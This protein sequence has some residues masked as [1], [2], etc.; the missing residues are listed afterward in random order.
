MNII[1]TG[2]GKGIGFELCKIFLKHSGTH[3]LAISRDITQLEI[4][5]K[6][7]PSLRPFAFDLENSNYNLIA[8]QVASLPEG[9][10]D[11]L[12]NN[13]GLLINKRF[14]DLDIEDN[15]KMLAVNYLAPFNLV[16]ALLPCFTVDA[17]IVNI[18][19]MG[20][21]Q[22][23]AKFIGLS[24]YSASKAALACLTECLAGELKEQNIKVNCLCL[25]A[26][27]TEMFQSAFPGNEAPVKA[28]EMA[29]FIADFAMKAHHFMN[30][31][32]IPVTLSEP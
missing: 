18:S 1:V 8:G 20:G 30:G 2:A 11:I 21:F 32:I 10:I 22:G 15:K 26:V 13:A 19:S 28:E 12:V 29:G 25:G 3:I 23:S 14:K 7:H 16:R 31:K 5:A 9:K 27:Q 6:D 24:G 4:L 17:H